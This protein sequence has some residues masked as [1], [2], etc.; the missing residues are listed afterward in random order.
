M[1][2]RRSMVSCA[3]RGSRAARVSTV[4]FSIQSTVASSPIIGAFIVNANLLTQFTPGYE[5]NNL[6]SGE[7]EQSQ[8]S[9]LFSPAY[10]TES[11]GVEYRPTDYF[12]VT[13]SPG[14]VRQTVV[15]DLDLYKTFPKNYGV[16]IGQR[17]RTELAL[18]QLVAN[19]NK[20]IAKNVNLKFRY[21]VFAN[22]KKLR[23]MDNRLDAML[24]AK[25][26]KYLN[27]NIGAIVIYDD[28]QSTKVQFAQSLSV[29]FL[30]TF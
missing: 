2:F 16:P 27:F 24:T 10:I 11:V 4:Y 28:D 18:L 14:A 9:G 22:Y 1:I 29:G 17:V 5:F 26:N 8:V 6:P 30:Y 19:F 20:D 25:V 3:T 12:F 21:V 23:S 13:F 15:A 7:I